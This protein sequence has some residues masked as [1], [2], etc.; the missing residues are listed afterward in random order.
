MALA[1]VV[2]ALGA[3]AETPL[4]S[5]ASF[6]AQIATAQGLVQVC[7]RAAGGCDAAAVPSDVQVSDEGHSF[8]VDW[9]WLR[10]AIGSAKTAPADER[11]KK[12][13]EAGD[14]LDELSAEAVVPAASDGAQFT[15]AKTVAVGVLAQ[16][17]F[18]AAAG[19]TWLERQMARVQDWLMQLLMGM[20]RIG[21]H[22]PW[23]APLVEWVCFLLAAGGL[24]F[25]VRQSLAR[26]ALRIALGEVAMTAQRDVR[27][28]VDWARLAAERAVAG[29]WREGIHCLYWAAILS[30]ETRRA[31]RPNPTRTPREYLA[32]LRPGSE[33]TRALA[34]LTRSFEAVWYGHAEVGEA[35]FRAAQ[36]N[37]AAIEAAELRGV[38]AGPVPVGAA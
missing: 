34:E 30:L 16:P 11:E 23:L 13:R 26:Q 3:R 8:R 10:E 19:P 27:D 35:T 9:G 15:Q 4:L 28:A 31:W 21:A 37:L 24:V 29:D 33:A 17:E 20:S 1:F 12:M 22:N 38:G 6:R 5:L 36:A 14:H 25:F 32:L 18:Q 7:G 2:S